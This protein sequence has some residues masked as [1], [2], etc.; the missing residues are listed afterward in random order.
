[1]AQFAEDRYQPNPEGGTVID[2]DF[3][4]VG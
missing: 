2:A 3:W 1:M 4:E